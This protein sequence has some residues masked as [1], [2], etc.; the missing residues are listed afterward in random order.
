MYQKFIKRLIDII[1]SSIALIIL[2]PIILILWI[3]LTFA[4]K[5]AGAF[6]IQKRPGK[7]CKI[8]KVVKFKTMTDEI[9]SSGNLLPDIDR[10]TPIGKF[11]RAT[12]LDEIP[13]LLNV[14]KGD[15][16]LIGPRPL[17]VEFLPLYSDEQNRRHNIR[18]GITGLAQINGRNNL[19][20]SKKFEF[21]VYYVDNISLK[22]DLMILI[23]TISKVFKRKDI[24]Y[25]ATN[26]EEVDD[27][28]WGEK[29][30]S[31]NND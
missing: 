30:T 5:G 27:L 7:N 15:M 6:F 17:L 10:L 4:N 24:G 29:L 31:R 22:L 2:S 16:S 1:F 9:D 21:D 26:D 18:P 14:F 8:F 13:Q 25:G 19:K 20:Y 11:V 23:K 28:G 3:W 12:S